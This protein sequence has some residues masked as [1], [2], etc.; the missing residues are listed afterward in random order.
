MTNDKIDGLVVFEINGLTS[1]LR[2]WF[3]DPKM[4]DQ[5]T[6]SA[7]LRRFFH[8]CRN[9]KRQILWVN[10][11]NANAIERYAHYGFRAET[12]TDII[13]KRI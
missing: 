9:T 10:T 11:L 6:G 2:Y 5:K 8:E 3:V 12:M 1:H 4:R 13:M 7:L